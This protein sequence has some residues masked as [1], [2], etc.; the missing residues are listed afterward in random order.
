M[1]KNDL[2]L[3]RGLPICLKMLC[4]LIIGIHSPSH[5]LSVGV[6][7]LILINRLSIYIIFL[8]VLCG[9]SNDINNQNRNSILWGQ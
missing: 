7:M 3:F 4:S 6:T 2:G 9:V 5:I 8:C 1:E